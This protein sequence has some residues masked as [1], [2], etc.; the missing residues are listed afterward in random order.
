[1]VEIHKQPSEA[2]EYEIFSLVM[3]MKYSISF[4]VRT[5]E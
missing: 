2:Y 5:K 4:Q 3:S 1:M